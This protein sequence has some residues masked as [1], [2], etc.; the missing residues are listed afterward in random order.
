[1]TNL[2]IPRLCKDFYAEGEKPLSKL[3]LEIIEDRYATGSTIIAS[4]L[5]VKEW[6]AC[7]GDPTIA[8]AICDRLFHVSHKFEMKG[9]SMRKKQKN[10]D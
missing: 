5:P 7:I 10:I 1:M 9:G 4:Q 6:H 8:D 2:L 3:T